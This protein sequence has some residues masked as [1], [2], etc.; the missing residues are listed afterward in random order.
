MMNNYRSQIRRSFS[1]CGKGES[2]RFSCAVGVKNVSLVLLL[3]LI[4]VLVLFTSLNSEVAPVTVLHPAL[5]NYRNLEILHSKK[6]TCPC[7]NTALL[8]SD[9]L[10]LSPILHQICSNEFISD[11]RI[12]T[13]LS[14]SGIYNSNHW[15]N[16][17]YSYFQLLSSFCEFSDTTAN[18]AVARFLSKYFVLS[19]VI[20]ETDFEKQFNASLE[21][22]YQS[23]F[24]YFSLLIDTARLLA[25]T[26]QPYFNS[27]HSIASRSI[28]SILSLHL[29][30]NTTNGH[31]SFKVWIVQITLSCSHAVTD[32][33]T[34]FERLFE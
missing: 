4:I 10:A 13:L 20:S 1:K 32:L 9:F 11:G 8:Y 12:G 16:K 21:Q 2:W 19:S 26:D 31:Q 5:E 34:S 33:R 25:Q 28:N 7:T 17:I 15:R 29:V 6:L 30:S 22:F 24:N 23:T 18:D 14:L 3:G 27:A